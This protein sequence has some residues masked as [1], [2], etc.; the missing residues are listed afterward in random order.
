MSLLLF[1]IKKIGFFPVSK[2]AD[3]H[4]SAIINDKLNNLAELSHPVH[5]YIAAVS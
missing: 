1:S 5:K 4:I 3:E 2:T